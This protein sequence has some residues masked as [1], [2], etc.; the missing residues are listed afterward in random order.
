MPP[1]SYRTVKGYGEAEIVIQKSRFIAQVARAETE[2]EAVAFITA[3]KAKHWDATHNCSAY[4]VGEHDQ[5]QRSSDDGE[6][7]GTAG[8]PILETIKRIGLKNTVVVVTRYFGGIKLGASGLIRAYAESAAAGI[9]A[10]GIVEKALC[11]RLRVTVGYSDWG[12]LEHWMRSENLPLADVAY[13]DTVQAFLL[14][15]LGTSA[16]MATR[17]ADITSGRAKVEPSGTVWI[18]RDVDSRAHG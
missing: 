14:C 11:E 10:A 17:I 4:V 9:Q 2:E 1:A 8:R 5:W 18:E 12:R 3:V 16:T 13:T 15:P 6:P 7:S